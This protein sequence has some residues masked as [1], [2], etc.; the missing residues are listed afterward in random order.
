MWWESDLM[1]HF[2]RKNLFPGSL[3]CL[4]HFNFHGKCFF[5]KGEIQKFLKLLEISCLQVRNS[6]LIIIIMLHII[7]SYMLVY[8]T[9]IV[10][11]SLKYFLVWLLFF[12]DLCSQKSYLS[13]WT[14]IFMYASL[15]TSQEEEWKTTE[16]C[17]LG[18]LHL[19]Q[20]YIQGIFYIC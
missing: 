10:E 5:L 17:L 12:V 14:S 18:H 16:W 2:Q 8:I 7:H 9:T 20:S 11:V 1:N 13:H 6:K 15:V 3:I 19:L 4:Q